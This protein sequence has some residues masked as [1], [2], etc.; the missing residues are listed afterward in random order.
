M[1][2]QWRR[3]EGWLGRWLLRNMNKRHSRV[4]DWGLSHVSIPRDGAILDVGCGG[5]RTIAKLAAASG[6]GMVSG[7]DHSA[8][9]VRVAALTNAELIQSSRIAIREGSVSQLPYA[10][11]AFDLVTAVETH[12]F[13]PDLPGNVREVWRVTKPG[14]SFAIIAE[15]YMG[16]NAATSRMVEKYAPKAGM[17]L[18]TP[19]EHQSLLEKAGFESVRVFSVASKGWICALGRKPLHEP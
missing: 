19:D 16:A 12:F 3:P 18:L 14:G 15:A 5:G 9:S 1:K 17:T 2:N 8:D 6:S 10:D 7:L 13:W 4:T 11:D